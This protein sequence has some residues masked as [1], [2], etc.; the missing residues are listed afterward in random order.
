MADH[1]VGSRVT[2]QISEPFELIA[3]APLALSGTVTEVRGGD[4]PSLVVA[5]DPT[6]PRLDSARLAV[7]SARHTGDSVGTL[8]VGNA[9]HVHGAFY[10]ERF[11]NQLDFGFI[12]RLEVTSIVR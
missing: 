5:L 3:D 2:I 6:D 10:S 8:T 11:Q 12:G 9:M 4:R 1:L 7:A